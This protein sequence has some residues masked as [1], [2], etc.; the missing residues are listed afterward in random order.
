M[1]RFRYKRQKVNYMDKIEG[2]VKTGYSMHVMLLVWLIIRFSSRLISFS[3]G[4]TTPFRWK[5]KTCR[6]RIANCRGCYTR[7]ES[8][9]TGNPKDHFIDRNLKMM[10]SFLLKIAIKVYWNYKM[11]VKWV[12]QALGCDIRLKKSG[13]IAKRIIAIALPST[14]HVISSSWGCTSIL[15]TSEGTL[16]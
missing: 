16:S 4:Q 14:I 7:Y 15:C 1:Q 8:R 5:Y 11:G 12:M 10:V 9:T 6:E 3:W 2:L 13:K